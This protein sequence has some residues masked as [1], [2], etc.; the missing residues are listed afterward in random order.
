LGDQHKL[1][2]ADYLIEQDGKNWQV[3]AIFGSR[4]FCGLR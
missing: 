4:L 2:L 3:A 1:N